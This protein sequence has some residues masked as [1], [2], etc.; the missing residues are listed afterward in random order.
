LVLKPIRYNYKVEAY[1]SSATGSQRKQKQERYL[2]TWLRWSLG[3]IH[4]YV[5][6]KYVRTT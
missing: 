1:I 3:T 2:V 4:K 6:I 5:T